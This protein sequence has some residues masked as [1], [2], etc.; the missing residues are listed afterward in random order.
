MDSMI[1]EIAIQH[2][3]VDVVTPEGFTL[4]IEIP[5]FSDESNLDDFSD[6][7]RDIKMT[8]EILVKTMLA[9][10]LKG[11]NTVVTKARV[12]NKISFSEELMT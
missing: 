3:K 1:E 2:S 6:T 12:P 8:A 4:R 5:D 9:P 7:T 10:P 11:G